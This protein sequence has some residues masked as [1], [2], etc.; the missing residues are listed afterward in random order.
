MQTEQ[1]WRPKRFPGKILPRK[2]KKKDTLKRKKV[3]GDHYSE[4]ENIKLLA[5]PCEET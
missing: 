2:K 3:L 5:V 4:T 1:R